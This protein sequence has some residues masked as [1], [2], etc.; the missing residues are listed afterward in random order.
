MRHLLKYIIP[1]FCFMALL[2][3]DDASATMSFSHY[4][5]MTEEV[6]EEA[7]FQMPESEYALIRMSAPSNIQSLLSNSR[8]NDSRQKHVFSFLKICNTMET[9]LC[10]FVRNNLI[11]LSLHSIFFEPSHLLISFCKF[12]I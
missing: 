5:P 7:D 8:R 4:N 2:C 12:I 1:L 11:L 3:N 9:N 6:F 10:V